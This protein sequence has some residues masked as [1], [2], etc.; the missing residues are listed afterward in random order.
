MKSVRSG[1]E[2]QGK[3]P[4][5]SHS[6]SGGKMVSEIYIGTVIHYFGKI[7]VAVLSLTDPIHI[8]D[9]IRIRGNDTEFDQEVTSLQ[10]D[11]E[12]VEYRAGGNRGRNAG[13]SIRS[14]WVSDLQVVDLTYRRRADREGHG[15]AVHCPFDNRTVD[16]SEVLGDWY[17][18]PGGLVAADEMALHTMGWCLMASQHGD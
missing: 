9:K 6:Q 14:P 2:F 3:V 5:L 10:A 8:G 1:A 12:A 13:H 11:H 16:D 15:K 4:F 18:G 7:G 17:Y